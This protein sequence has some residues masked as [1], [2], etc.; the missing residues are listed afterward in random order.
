MRL[1][2]RKRRRETVPGPSTAERTL[3][4]LGPALS[5]DKSSIPAVLLVDPHAPSLVLCMEHIQSGLGGFDILVARIPE[6]AIQTFEKNQDRITSVVISQ[7]M[8]QQHQLRTAGNSVAQEIRKIDKEVGIAM[9]CGTLHTP[10]DKSTVADAHEE[11]AIIGHQDQFLKVVGDMARL[12]EK[13]RPQKL[14]H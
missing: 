9:L 4:E 13:R 2:R 10:S 3:A 6:V 14:K 5:A 12:T 11:K 1:A 8:G 7:S